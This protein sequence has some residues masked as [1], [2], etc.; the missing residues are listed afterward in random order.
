MDRRSGCHRRRGPRR[1]AEHA[2]RAS[3]CAETRLRERA[4]CDESAAGGRPHLPAALDRGAVRACCAAGIDQ[5]CRWKSRHRVVHVV[6]GVVTFAAEQVARRVEP[7]HL[8]VGALRH[9]G[10]VPA[11][12]GQVERLHARAGFVAQAFDAD[13]AQPIGRQVG[14]EEV[15]ARFAGQREG[16]DALV[17]C[18]QGDA[19]ATARHRH[20][21]RI[22]KIYVLVSA[23]EVA[24]LAVGVV[25]FGTQPAVRRRGPVRCGLA[26]AVD[27]ERQARIRAD[28]A[29]RQVKR[30][31]APARAGVICVRRARISCLDFRS[32]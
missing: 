6:G 27:R 24:A 31:R 22:R 23:V 17:G 3:A 2:T 16:R 30:V 32:C 20:A 19:V 4:E 25:R 13:Q 11:P 28:H 12:A 10:A 5:Q 26:R 15:A 21:G 9:E 18:E 29:R 7:A 14:I 1:I 8:V